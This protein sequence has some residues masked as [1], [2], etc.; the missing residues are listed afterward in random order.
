M[1]LSPVLVRNDDVSKTTAEQEIKDTLSEIDL[2]KKE[3]LLLDE[4]SSKDIDG[5]KKT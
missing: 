1:Y 2:L 5:K 4:T 3:L